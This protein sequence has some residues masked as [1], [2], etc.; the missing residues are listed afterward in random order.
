MIAPTKPELTPAEEAEEAAGLIWGSDPDFTAKL[1]AQGVVRRDAE[2]VR[3]LYRDVLTDRDTR[4]FHRLLYTSEGDA[5]FESEDDFDLFKLLALGTRDPE[6]IERIARTSPRAE[7]ARWNNKWGPRTWAAQS[8]LNALDKTEHEYH[9]RLLQ[10]TAP[11]LPGDAPEPDMPV[12][13]SL[14]E[15]LKDPDALKPPRP[16]SRGWRGMVA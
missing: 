1:K 5:R 15:Y 13:R 8:I 11:P 6:Q 14:A 9:R 10:R 2:V 3:L 12:R 4:T 16:G 7:R